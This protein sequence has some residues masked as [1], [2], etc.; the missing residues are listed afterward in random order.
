VGLAHAQFE[1]IHPFLDGNGRIGRLL[2]TFLLVEH[3]ALHKPILYLSHY[4]KRFRQEYYDHLQSIRE[5]G[6]WEGWL[7]FFLQGVTDVSTQAWKTARK[8]LSLREK[9]RERITTHLGQ[10]A[11]NGLKVLEYLFEKPIVSVKEVQALI[12]TSYPPANDLVR[13]LVEQNVLMETTGH[14]RN[15]RFMFHSYVDLFREDKP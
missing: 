8:I 14:I 6:D 2:I 11:G 13:R 9:L 7:K 15:R 10:A 12:G 1:T 5:T 4:F 3:G